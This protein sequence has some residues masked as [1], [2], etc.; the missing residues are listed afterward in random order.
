MHLRML[1]RVWPF[2][3]WFDCFFLF[4]FSF[5]C[6][7]LESMHCCWHVLQGSCPFQQC[8]NILSFGSIRTYQAQLDISGFEHI[9]HIM[10][11]C[12][13]SVFFS[14]IQLVRVFWMERS[15]KKRKQ[16]SKIVRKLCKWCIPVV[17]KLFP[18]NPPCLCPRRATYT[19]TKRCIECDL[20]SQKFLYQ[21]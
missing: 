10:P 8:W 2:L 7:A 3:L 9:R 20:G 15:L 17:P 6:L 21:T 12:H 1:S 11:L 14:A 4:Q 16:L 19:N 13:L 18:W 5:T